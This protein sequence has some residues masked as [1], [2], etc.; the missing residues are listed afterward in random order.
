MRLREWGNRAR[1]E[2]GF[3]CPVGAPPDRFGFRATIC[4]AGLRFAKPAS[5]SGT[6]IFHTIGLH[7]GNPQQV[8]PPTHIVQLP[9]KA[10][11]NL[12]IR[13]FSQ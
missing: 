5:Q 8:S 10:G 12:L 1:S 9:A 11:G 2:P 13:Q 7:R 6:S 3:K 4:L